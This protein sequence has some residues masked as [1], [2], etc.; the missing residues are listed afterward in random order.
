ML[1]SALCSI[2]FRELSVEE[3]IELCAESGIQA[4]EW[5]GDVHVPHGDVE[6]AREV[7]EKTEAAGLAICAYGSYYKCDEETVRFADVLASAEAL[8]T[9]II[10]IWAGTQGSADSSTENRQEVAARIRSAVLS[11]QDKGITVAL[12]Y[13]GGTLTDTQESAHQL[14]EEV[15]LSEL[16]LF[17]QP[18]AG[19]SFPKD[20]EELKAA[21]P[22]LAN[23]HCFHWGPGGWKDRYALSDGIEPWT[24]YL[25][26]IRTAGGDRYIT[27]E[28]VAENSPDQLRDDARTLNQLL[29]AQTS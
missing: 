21:L 24:E 3:I 27:L 22:H 28:F 11:A 25:R 20:L 13:H 4:I 8:G 12:E 2:T 10:R 18:R 15:G 7:R 1:Q 23:V 9:R 29:N 26:L 17:W 16:K 6:L 5:G 14:L 19:G